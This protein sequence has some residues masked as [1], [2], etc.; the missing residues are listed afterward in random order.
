MRGQALLATATI[1]LVVALLL[2]AAVPK[3]TLGPDPQIEDP[4]IQRRELEHMLR[5]AYEDALVD[6]AQQIEAVLNNNAELDSQLKTM[7]E[8][9]WTKKSRIYAS[10]RG[11]QCEIR[12]VPQIEIAQMNIKGGSMFYVK[13]FYVEAT[14]NNGAFATL[15]SSA[16]VKAELK[17]LGVFGGLKL[18][19]TLKRGNDLIYIISFGAM[20]YNNTCGEK[21]WVRLPLLG[22]FDD[23]GRIWLFNTTAA[24]E[25]R[26]A[27]PPE[28]FDLNK[29]YQNYRVVVVAV[30]PGQGAGTLV[31]VV[32]AKQGS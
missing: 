20:L 26:V 14:C 10:L 17:P 23:T 8:I 3:R 1:I 5:A 18:N 31:V 12:Q 21:C 30:T 15:S 9:Q 4:A 11:V 13:S 2:L 28:Y 22:T 6:T 25:I 32:P 16:E 19:V 27:I 7:F 29:N 24:Q